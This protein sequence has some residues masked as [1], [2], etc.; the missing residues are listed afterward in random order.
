MKFKPGDI[1]DF[2]SEYVLSLKE[3]FLVLQ[4][5]KGFLYYAAISPR[6]YSFKIARG[7][8]KE[9]EGYIKL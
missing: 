5:V 6:P 4:I 7:D 3:P 2:N 9:F 8:V 1:I